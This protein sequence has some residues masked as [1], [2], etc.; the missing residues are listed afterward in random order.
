MITVLFNQAISKTS[1]T[2][3]NVNPSSKTPSPDNKTAGAM[4]AMDS[5]KINSKNRFKN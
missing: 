5:E 4:M 3:F 2:T 1:R